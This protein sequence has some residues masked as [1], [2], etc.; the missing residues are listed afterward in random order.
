[1]VALRPVA[2]ADWPILLEWA[3]DLATRSN[4]LHPEPIDPET[5]RRWLAD[6]LATSG[7]RLLIGEEQ[8]RPVGFVRVEPSE[9]K[10]DVSITVSP[11]HRRRGVG[12]ALLAAAMGSWLRDPG[13]QGSGFIARIRPDNAASISIFEAAGFT[14]R[15]TGECNGVP[16]LRYERD[17]SD[18][19]PADEMGG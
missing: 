17:R 1:M 8:G 10:L 15:S 5:H 11:A 13:L 9:G 12:Q 14:F 6:R 19:L 4:S 3:N 7:H 18:P 2:Q 16:C